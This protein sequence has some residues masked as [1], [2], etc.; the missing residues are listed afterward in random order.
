MSEHV[1]NA[2]RFMADVNRHGFTDVMVK[3]YKDICRLVEHRIDKDS[4]V[5][6]TFKGAIP[7]A[8]LIFSM[9]HLLAKA[10]KPLGQVVPCPVHASLYYSFSGFS[11]WLA[12]IFRAELQ[13]I[14]P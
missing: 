12:Q 7:P 4:L 6:A 10:Q 9:L 11:C 3:I 14:V 8:A 13:G 2:G 5:A 1:L